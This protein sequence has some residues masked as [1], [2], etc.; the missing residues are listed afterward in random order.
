[1][2]TRPIVVGVDGGPDSLAALQWGA[3]YARA[4]N[5]PLIALTAYDLPTI[6]GPY[7]MVGW[8]SA[9]E[10]EAGARSMLE[11]A[12]QDTLGADSGVQLVVRRGHPAES[13]VAESAEAGLVVMGSRGRGGFA[14]LLLGSVSQ[15]VVA[16]AH[17]PVVVL[18]HQSADS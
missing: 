13:L 11:G 15:H 17:C 8:E 2:D 14:G 4:V 10:L 1:M 5:A 6:Y 16:H 9:S 7:A 3:E 18:P 12:V